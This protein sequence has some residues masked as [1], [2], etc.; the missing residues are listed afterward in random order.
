MLIGTYKAISVLSGEFSQMRR[1]T[2]HGD[3]IWHRMEQNEEWDLLINTMWKYQYTKYEVELTPKLSNALY[4]ESQ[5][6]TDFAV[7]IFGLAQERAIENGVEKI[8]IGGIRAVAKDYIN[9]PRVVLNALKT[10]DLRVLKQFEDAYPRGFETNFHLSTLNNSKI[11]EASQNIQDTR[12][13]SEQSLKQ[14]KLIDETENA[15]CHIDNQKARGVKPVLKKPK[16]ND[17]K[18]KE[19]MITGH[20]S[21]PAKPSNLTLTKEKKILIKTAEKV[22]KNDALAIYE[23]LKNNG[24]LRPSDEFYS[25]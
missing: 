6:I 4:E 19:I 8:T 18:S 9:I 14:E 21:N 22:D 13:T 2:G 7:K 25:Y 16:N 10:G 3:F 20:S 17:V 5:G 24:Y 11:I 15:E 23:A 1:G 12:Q